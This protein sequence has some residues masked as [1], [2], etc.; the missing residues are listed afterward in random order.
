M[1][2]DKKQIKLFLKNVGWIKSVVKKLGTSEDSGLL[3]NTLEEKRDETKELEKSISKKI[4][5]RRQTTDEEYLSY[6]YGDRIYQIMTC[7]R[8][9]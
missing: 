8:M 9:K 1:D 3:R 4:E 2:A 6:N 5:A 7:H